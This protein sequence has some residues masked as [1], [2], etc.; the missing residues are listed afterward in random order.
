MNSSLAGAAES[1]QA[2]SQ[3]ATPDTGS[4][5]KIKD[6]GAFSMDEIEGGQIYPLK[7]NQGS[8]KIT[9]IRERVHMVRLIGLIFDSNKCFLLPYA[10]PGIKQIIQM[11]EKY[12]TAEVLIV[13]HAGSDEDLAGADIAFDR[14][15]I[16]GAYLKNKPTIWLNWFGPDKNERSRWGTREIQLMLSALPDLKNCF[17]SGFASGISDEKTTSAIK[18]FQEYM[19]KEKNVSLPVDGKVDFE[20]RKALVEAYMNIE[21]TSFSEEVHPVAHGCEGHFKGKTTSTGN[22]ADDRRIEVLF[23]EKMISPRPQATISTEGTSFYPK[24]VSRVVE[25][26]DYEHHGI[27]IQIIDAKN[28]PAPL[29]KVTLKGPV[30][31]ESTAD[32]YGF[33]SFFN[34]KKGEYTINSEKNGYKIGASKITYPTAKT[35]PG[36]SGKSGNGK[37]R[38][39]K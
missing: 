1:S 18:K 6:T 17:Y 39:R 7:F 13:G 31:A 38:S 20:T 30:N 15:Q 24:W 8:H 14:A 12:K 21:G 19:K 29:A 3:T 37:D 34:L 33:V 9:L 10:L 27:H 5:P 16:L 25:I 32:E 11:H 4:S 35:I 36:Y 23:F 22:E 28:K 2:G 26:V